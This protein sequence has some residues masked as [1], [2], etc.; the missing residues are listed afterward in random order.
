MVVALT[1]NKKPHEIHRDYTEASLRRYLDGRFV[2]EQEQAV[3][4]GGRRL[5]SLVPIV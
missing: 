5:F 4:A 2:I 1:A 3:P